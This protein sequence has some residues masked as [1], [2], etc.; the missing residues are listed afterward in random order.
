MGLLQLGSGGHRSTTVSLSRDSL[1]ASTMSEL[2]LVLGDY[3]V[4]RVGTRGAAPIAKPAKPAAIQSVFGSIDRTKVLTLLAVIG[5]ATIVDL[6]RLT[7]IAHNSLRAVLA[8]F[9]REGVVRC[10]RV[11]PHVFASLN[12]RFFAAPQLLNLCREVAKALPHMADAS[13]YQD[14]R[15]KAA[16]PAPRRGLPPHELVPFGRPTQVKLLLT[17]AR[18]GAIRT[19]DLSVVTEMTQNAVRGAS[20]SLLRAGLIVCRAEKGGRNVERW[21]SL[22]RAYP[23][24]QAL[25]R[26]LTAVA[27]HTLISK[28]IGLALRRAR[29][30]MLPA[31]IRRFGTLAS[32]GSD[33]RFAVLTVVATKPKRTAEEI[34]DE[35][36]L[37]LWRTRNHLWDLAETGVISYLPLDGR[38][39]AKINGR[40]R[41]AKELWPL[42]LNRSC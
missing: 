22:N 19:A 7:G 35:I 18:V 11:P 14:L 27:S 41:F 2:L 6:S 10:D 5:S 13:L 38:F 23:T 34:A 21:Y 1:F 32:L 25:H 17:L 28:R 37:P 3:R 26:F 16:T 42:L 36:R 39:R 4:V 24:F 9:V 33:S 29:P 40:F 30:D 12:D 31:R 15:L 20:Q 8:H